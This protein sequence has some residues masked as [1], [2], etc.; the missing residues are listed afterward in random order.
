MHVQQHV[1]FYVR[2]ICTCLL[3]KGYLHTFEE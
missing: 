3:L 2:K 1:H